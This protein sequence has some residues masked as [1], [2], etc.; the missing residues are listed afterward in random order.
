MLKNTNFLALSFAFSPFP[1]CID[2]FNNHVNDYF[3]GDIQKN[4][5]AEKI[6]QIENFFGAF[7]FFEFCEDLLDALFSL[8]G[9]LLLHHQRH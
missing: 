2:L 8:R 9:R 4:K 6:S 5:R 7:L 3:F 1:K